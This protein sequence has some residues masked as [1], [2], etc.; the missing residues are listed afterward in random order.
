MATYRNP[1][2]PI[3]QPG[4]A[5]PAR[6]GLHSYTSPQAIQ[7]TCVYHAEIC[8]RVN[9][10]WYLQKDGFYEIT[11]MDSLVVLETWYENHD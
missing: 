8:I 10:K 2:I 1:L 5:L 3:R 4:F 6:S 9:D 11:D 7:A